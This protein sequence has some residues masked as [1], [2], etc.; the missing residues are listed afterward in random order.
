MHFSLVDYW[1]A[2]LA[3]A[4]PFHFFGATSSELGVD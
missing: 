2:S 4:I 3:T 1:Y